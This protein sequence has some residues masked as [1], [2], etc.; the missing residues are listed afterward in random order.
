MKEAKNS[1]S[2]AVQA[3]TFC[4]KFAIKAIFYGK[5]NKVYV[6][7]IIQCTFYS[8]QNV[9]VQPAKILFCNT[10]K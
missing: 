1:T 3:C 5:V 4:P 2:L 6:F 9:I 10:F 8:L 7:L